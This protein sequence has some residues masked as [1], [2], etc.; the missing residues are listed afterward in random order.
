MDFWISKEIFDWLK[1][2]KP[3]LIMVTNPWNKKRVFYDIHESGPRPE[4][5]YYLP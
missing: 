2:A 1:N 3:S 4:P 5:F